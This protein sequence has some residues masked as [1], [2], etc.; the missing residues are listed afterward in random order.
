MYTIKDYLYYYK[1]IDTNEVHW[2]QID[3]LLCSILVYLPIDTF[4]TKKSLKEFIEYSN[5]FKNRI[6]QGMMSKKSFELLSLL[7]NSKRYSSLYISNFINL[8]D[9]NTQFGACKF[10]IKDETT[11]SFKGTNGSSIGWIENL[12]LGYTYP[13]YTQ[14]L[15]IKYLKENI[16]LNDNKIYVSGHSKGGNLAMTSVM[17]LPVKQQKKIKNIYNF[18]GPGFLT[19]EFNS[20]KFKKIEDKLIN[21]VP[22]GSVIGII[23]NNDNY[24]VVKSVELGVYEHFPTSWCIFG[25]NFIEGKLS[26][27]SKKLHI[28]TTI[29]L[30]SLDKE[31]LSSAIEQIVK[32]VLDNKD[33]IH[34][35]NDIT[36][37][38]KSIQNIDPKVQKYLMKFINTIISF[39]SKEINVK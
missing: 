30:E 36:K 5:Q 29:G 33:N 27:V 7:T 24:K 35:I 3:N 37:L 6:N 39:K 10:K 14:T 28:N 15:A 26:G 23:L 18:D 12:R 25:E 9:E 17:E 22:T 2:N 16:S 19:N 1:D 20:M 13:T 4:K 32:L 38:I 34:S 21:I 31:Q 8:E 11:I